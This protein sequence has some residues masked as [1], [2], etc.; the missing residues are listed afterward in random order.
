MGCSASNIR[1]VE[2][3]NE[4]RILYKSTKSSIVIVGEATERVDQT[5]L[6]QKQELI[7]EEI[8]KS[9]SNSKDKENSI[10]GNNINKNRNE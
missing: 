3:S 6:I 8:N 10:N 2:K 5:D 9:K 4:D 1:T 7:G